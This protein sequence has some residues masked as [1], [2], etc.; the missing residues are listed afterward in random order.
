[1]ER[2]GKERKGKERKGLV[3]CALIAIVALAFVTCD[4]GNGKDDG[5]GPLSGTFTG[6]ADNF[7]YHAQGTTPNGA[8]DPV[9]DTLGFSLVFAAD[10]LT[11][12]TTQGGDSSC[13]NRGEDA[14]SSME[15]LI[16]GKTKAQIDALTVEDY[17]SKIVADGVA[18]ATAT[19]STFVEAWDNV[20]W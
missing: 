20:T 13:T 17:K 3:L 1:M 19:A 9:S 10:I 5:T 2:K 11:S 15:N 8:T 12:I 6:Q 18:K 7:G 4:N 14:V 16:L